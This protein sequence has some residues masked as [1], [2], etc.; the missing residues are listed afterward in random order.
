M[1]GSPIR[2]CHSCNKKYL[3]Q[4]YREIAIDG[5]DPRSVD[6]GFYLKGTGLFTIGFIVCLVWLLYQINYLGYYQIR[7]A[8][9]VFICAFGAVMC[10]ILFIRNKLGIDEKKNAQY[11]EESEKR[12]MDK[13][14][15][16]ELIDYGLNVPEKYR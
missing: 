15:V 7:L 12:L 5:V 8:G 2:V 3:D 4:R 16:Q 10:A 1:Y 9:C 14:Y 6:P 13:T 11:L